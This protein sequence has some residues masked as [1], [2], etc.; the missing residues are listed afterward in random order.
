MLESVR[1]TAQ[2]NAFRN[3]SSIMLMNVYLEGRELRQSRGAAR[4]EFQGPLSAQR[5][6]RSEAISLWPDRRVNG[7][8]THLAR[9]RAFGISTAGANLPRQK[10]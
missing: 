4:R 3:I 9:Y 2:D 6:N 10:R 5:M 1:A 7:A 8:R